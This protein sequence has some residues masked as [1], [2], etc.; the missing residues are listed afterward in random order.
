MS[1]EPAF[2][3]E[4][5]QWCNERR[6]EK[7]LGPLDRLPKG[8]RTNVMTCPCGTASGTMVGKTAW[9]WPE[10]DG[11]VAPLPEAVASFVDAFDDGRLPQ[12]EAKR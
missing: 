11:T 6:A 1:A 12:Y 4:T 10:D 9:W 3:A 7:G 8:D 2:V 5:L